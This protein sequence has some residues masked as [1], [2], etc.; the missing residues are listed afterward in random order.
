MWDLPLPLQP[1]IAASSYSRA[2][3]HCSYSSQWVSYKL[4]RA[5]ASSQPGPPFKP[6]RLQTI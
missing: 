2:S 3:G 1:T 5:Q 6:H 4:S